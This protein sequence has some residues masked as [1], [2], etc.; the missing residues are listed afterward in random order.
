M[1][2]SKSMR[3]RLK[4]IAFAEAYRVRP[5]TLARLLCRGE[6]T[7][8]SSAEKPSRPKADFEDIERRSTAGSST[9][10]KYVVGIK[11]V[12]VNLVEV[13]ATSPEDAKE[14]AA[15]NSVGHS[16]LVEYSHAL[17]PE[18]WSVSWDERANEEV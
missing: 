1:T 7:S 16:L 17:D 9:L 6:E 13:W 12:H 8:V 10:K 2:S 18:T 4:A 14:E 5:E 15:A 3:P 11:E